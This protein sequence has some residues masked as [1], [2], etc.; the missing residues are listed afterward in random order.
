MKPAGVS[1]EPPV[2]PPPVMAPTVCATPPPVQAIPRQVG[3]S[4]LSGSVNVS[5]ATAKVNLVTIVEEVISVLASDPNGT[6]GVTVE[7]TAE[8]PKGAADH[9]KRAVSRNAG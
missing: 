8:Y 6:A 4:S 1:V 7:I 9:I 3:P 2:G 5:G